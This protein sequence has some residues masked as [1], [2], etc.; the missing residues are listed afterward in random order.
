MEHDLI[1]SIIKMD[2]S[3]QVIA[4]KTQ[5]KQVFPSLPLCVFCDS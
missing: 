5:S 3:F 4:Q 1:D 2:M